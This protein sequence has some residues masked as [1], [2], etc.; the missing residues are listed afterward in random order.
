V[1]TYNDYQL[2]WL[3]STGG[4]TEKYGL[5]AFFHSINGGFSNQPTLTG[6]LLPQNLYP[7]L[8]MVTLATRR[9]TIKKARQQADVS[10]LKSSKLKKA[11]CH[12][13][14]GFIR[15]CS[16]SKAQPT[17]IDTSGWHRRWCDGKPVAYRPS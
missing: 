16:T 3:A 10:T 14:A 12:V 7:V 5:H 6:C 1:I 17:A 11:I 8:V 4:L 2:T 9:H 13:N 15:R